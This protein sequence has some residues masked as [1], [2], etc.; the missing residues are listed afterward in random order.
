VDVCDLLDRRWTAGDVTDVLQERP[1]WLKDARRR[2]TAAKGERDKQ[3]QARLAAVQ[4]RRKGFTYPAVPA[5]ATEFAREFTRASLLNYLRRALD[6]AAAD[7]YVVDSGYD[8]STYAS[9]AAETNRERAKRG[10]SLSG[11]GDRDFSACGM[12]REPGT[13]GDLFDAP[14]GDTI[15]TYVSG[16]GLAA[17]SWGD[18]WHDRGALE[19]LALAYLVADL[20][21]NG[22]IATL[23]VI[24]EAPLGDA[25]VMTEGSFDGIAADVLSLARQALYSRA[26]TECPVLDPE[27]IVDMTA[28]LSALPG[29]LLGTRYE[30][31]RTEQLAAVLAGVAN[32]SVGIADGDAV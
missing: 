14:T 9:R 20:A 30:W 18:A 29:L 2:K 4:A 26:E 8:V 31:S 7:T 15:A 17:E 19:G 25:E 23:E 27:E 28:P 1:D 24:A 21:L 10:V 16:A 12:Y 22:E 5:E 3:R 11:L 32:D 6:A 13:L